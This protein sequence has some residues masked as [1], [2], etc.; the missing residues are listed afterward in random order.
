[1]LAGI[2]TIV[3]GVYASV[4]LGGGTS[5]TALLAIFGA[6]YRV[7][8]GISLSL[9]LVVTLIGSINFA[10]QGHLRKEVIV[11]VLVA[12]LPMS[13]LGGS[14]EVSARL[15]Y[16]ILLVTLLGVAARIYL[17]NGPSLQL[18]WSP[19]VERI[20]A[21]V[22]GAAIGLVGGLVGIGGG[23][24]LI[25]ALLLLGIADEKEAAAAGAVFTGLNSLT[26]LL[27]HLQRQI[28]DLRMMAPLLAAVLVGGFVGSHLGSARFSAKTVRRALG[29]VILVAIG[30]LIH[31]LV[32]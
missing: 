27:A 29:V 17:W 15:F 7:I 3:A 26:A 16:W 10:R 30:L 5:Y 1:L 9:N 12:S 11:P 20:V 2:F 24:Y 19:T 14:L 22:V 4:G 28:P 18:D 13:Y 6:S 25:P 23:I 32:F 21:L 8:P 31:R